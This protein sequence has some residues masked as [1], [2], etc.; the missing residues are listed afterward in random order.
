M[1]TRQREKCMETKR[2]QIDSKWNSIQIILAERNNHECAYNWGFTFEFA[3]SMNQ[4][5]ICIYMR[6]VCFAVQCSRCRCCCI[7]VWKLSKLMNTKHRL[8]KLKLICC[9][10]F[11][12]AVFICVFVLFARN[13]APNLPQFWL[14]SFSINNEMNI[15]ADKWRKQSQAILTV[16][17]TKALSFI[18]FTLL[19]SI[20]KQSES[21]MKIEKWNCDCKPS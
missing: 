4:N 16:I 3:A 15:W 8:H 19:F 10:L 9:L 20:R 17:M 7:W 2:L 18:D 5:T 13:K 6:D 11:F 1:A 12:I 21:Q 14:R